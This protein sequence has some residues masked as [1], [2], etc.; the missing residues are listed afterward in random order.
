MKTITR[1]DTLNDYDF[2][3]LYNKEPHPRV[4]IRLLALSH[5][6]EG[7]NYQQV[8]QYLKVSVLSVKNWLS[9]FKKQGLLGLSEKSRT[10]RNSQYSGKEEKIK[11]AIQTLQDN[12][13]GGRVRLLDIQLMLCN[14]FNIHYANLS[15]VHRL[16]GRLNISWISSRS[17]HP[18]QDKEAQ[19]LYKKLQTK[20]NRCPTCGYQL[21]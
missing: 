4:R 11:Q 9:N 2:V 16:L 7:K 5:I 12:K 15:G 13:T 3:S 20:G 10:G 17:S 21:S 14:Q 6:K 8:A 19:A 1:P 18:K